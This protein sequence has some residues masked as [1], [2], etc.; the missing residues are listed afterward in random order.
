M[1]SV[2]SMSVMYERVFCLDGNNL[3]VIH[4]CLTYLRIRKIIIN[5]HIKLLIDWFNSLDW[6][7]YLW[8][9]GHHQAGSN[10]TRHFVD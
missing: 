2:G 1:V 6:F 3:I 8:P 4:Q 7:S 9:S 10:L 5:D